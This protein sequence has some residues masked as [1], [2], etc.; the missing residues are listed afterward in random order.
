[1]RYV[2]QYA[3]KSGAGDAWRLAHF[4]DQ[5]KVDYFFCGLYD[6]FKG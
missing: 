2:V 6:N 5:R 4:T 1:M 3:K